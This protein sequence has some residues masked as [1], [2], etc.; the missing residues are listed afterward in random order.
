AIHLLKSFPPASEG[1]SCVGTNFGRTHSQ[2]YLA[3]LGATHKGALI[4][5]LVPITS[6]SIVLKI[7]KF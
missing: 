5:A 7:P 3:S 1:E 2:F 4:S 6:L